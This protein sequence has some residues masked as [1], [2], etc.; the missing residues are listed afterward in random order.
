M[1]ARPS[2]SNTFIENTKEQEDASFFLP[3]YLF[4]FRVSD[5]ATCANG[6]P[7]LVDL[8]D[9]S[10]REILDNEPQHIT[11]ARD[12]LHQATTLAEI[13]TENP[14][15][16][17]L[18]LQSQEEAEKSL[19]VLL[20]TWKEDCNTIQKDKRDEIN[21]KFSLSCYGDTH[22]IR[23]FLF[24]LSSAVKENDLTEICMA[25]NPI[26]GINLTLNRNM[27]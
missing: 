2:S 11:D 21:R 13:S 4:F 7:D 1:P 10:W 27:P 23:A 9:R 20:D 17:P 5:A 18:N 3:G 15:N 6:E 8:P 22:E 26:P 25:Y 14:D 24:Q 19:G 16:G 12:A